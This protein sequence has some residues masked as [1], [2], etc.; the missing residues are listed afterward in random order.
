MENSFIINWKTG[1]RYNGKEMI[2]ALKDIIENNSNDYSYNYGMA[3]RT[4]EFFK[5]KL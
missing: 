3:V 2:T 5:L 4:V 1:V